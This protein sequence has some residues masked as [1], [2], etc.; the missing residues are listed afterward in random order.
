MRYNT[1]GINAIGRSTDDSERKD[2]RKKE[3]FRRLDPAMPST[4]IEA[5][6]EELLED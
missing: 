4:E 3:L 6:I 2:E 1:E 5:L